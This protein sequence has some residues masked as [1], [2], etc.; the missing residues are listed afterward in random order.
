[1]HWSFQVGRTTL[2]LCSHHVTVFVWSPVDCCLVAHIQCALGMNL[3]M[4][5]ALQGMAHTG[6]PALH[7]NTAVHLMQKSRQ[8]WPTINAAACM[9]ECVQ[10]MVVAASDSLPWILVC[11]DLTLSSSALPTAGCLVQPCV[12]L[13][14]AWAVSKC[15]DVPGGLLGSRWGLLQV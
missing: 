1:L 7:V 2:L 13:H 6:L 10:H 14:S 12:L 4:A 3:P 5:R 11:E 9:H 15:F 8:V